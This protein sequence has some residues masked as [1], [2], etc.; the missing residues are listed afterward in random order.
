VTRDRKQGTSRLDQT[1]YIN[2]ILAKLSIEREFYKPTKS[3]IDFYN[4]LKPSRLTD[5]RC[6]KTKY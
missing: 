5:Q 6:N 1:Y 3:P 2:Y 4:N